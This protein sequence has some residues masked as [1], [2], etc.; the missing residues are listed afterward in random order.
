MI[1]KRKL[2]IKLAGFALLIW[3]FYTAVIV[4]TKYWYCLLN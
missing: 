4:T 2:A 1:D 3:G